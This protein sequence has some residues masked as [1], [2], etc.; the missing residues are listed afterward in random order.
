MN[1]I[2]SVLFLTA[3]DDLFAEIASKYLSSKFQ[4]CQ[5]YCS[6][7]GQKFPEEL[8][9][10]TG[11]Y[12]ISFLSRWI[13]PQKIL[14][15][16]KRECIN[17]HPGPPEYPGIGCTNFAIYEGASQ[18]GVTCHR[19]ESKVDTGDIISTMN[20]PIDAS[21]TIENLHDKTRHALLNLFKDII[22][23]ISENKSLT[24]SSENWTR[25]PFTRSQL[26]ELARINFS[27]NA[28]EVNRRIR[29]TSFKNWQPYIEF[30]GFRF[31]YKP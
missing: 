31:D 22:Q 5:I 1:R 6:E 9:S 18:F 10:W 4:N 28:D 16:A 19:M 29:A 26:D 30:Q 11:D 15:L 8:E 25:P 3:K 14:K 20:F 2:H 27:M 21:E 23:K 12:I 17:F 24:S 13:V 7:W